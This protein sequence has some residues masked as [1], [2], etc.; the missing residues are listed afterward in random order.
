M[1]GAGGRPGRWPAR[2]AVRKRAAPPADPCPA[3]GSAR[4]RPVVASGSRIACAFPTQS[5]H[6]AA[7]TWSGRGLCPG[8]P[9]WLGRCRIPLQGPF[10]PSHLPVT[11]GPSCCHAR[12]AGSPGERPHLLGAQTP[13]PLRILF[14]LPLP[15]PGAPWGSAL[16]GPQNRAQTLPPG[17]PPPRGRPPWGRGLRGGGLEPQPRVQFLWRPEPKSCDLHCVHLS[18]SL[19]MPCP[20]GRTRLRPQAGGQGAWTQLPRASGAPL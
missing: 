6:S 16:D 3:I 13:P 18:V 1:A 8:P 15:E 17:P 14:S 20:C 9:R 7:Q 11:L 5:L 12:A 19:G 4:T 2:A 10:R